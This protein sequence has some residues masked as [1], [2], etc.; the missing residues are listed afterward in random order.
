MKVK[1]ESSTVY[2]CLMRVKQASKE[3]TQAEDRK[4]YRRCKYREACKHDVVNRRHY[5]CVKNVEG[6]VQIVHLRNYAGYDHHKE[7]S[8]FRVELS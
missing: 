5:G 3:A 4:P 1:N 7:E 2:F 8:S 6:L